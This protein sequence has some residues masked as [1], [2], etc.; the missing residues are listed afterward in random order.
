MKQNKNSNLNLLYGNPTDIKEDTDHKTITAKQVVIDKKKYTVKDKKLSKYTWGFGLEHESHLFHM[1]PENVKKPVKD[2]TIYDTLNS[3]VDLVEYGNLSVMEKEFLESIPFEPTGRKCHGKWVL[4]KTPISMPEFVTKDPFTS[5]KTGKKT[6]EA[7]YQELLEYEKFFLRIQEKKTDKIKKYGQLYQFPYGMSTYIKLAKNYLDD[8]YKY[9][10]KLLTDYLG[11]FHVTITLPFITKDKYTK[12][13]EAEFRK[14]H[15]NFANQFQWIEPLLLSAFFSCDQKAVGSIS[16]R[17]RGS[18]RV[19]RVGWGNFAGTDVRSFDKGTGRYATIPSYWRDHLKFFEI[20]KLKPCYKP[21]KL[22]GEPD[23]LSLLSSNIRTFGSTDPERPWHRV[24]GAP[25]NI[26]NGI[27]IRIFDHFE[28]IYLISLLRI[29]T[30]IAA[31]SSTHHSDKYVYQNKSWIKSMHNIME[32]GWRGE[33]PK[34]YIKDLEEQLDIKLDHNV[35]N[36]Y[37]LLVNLTNQLWEKNKDNDITYMMSEKYLHAPDVP[38][39]NRGSWDFSFLLK[40][41]N[42]SVL[43]KK[44]CKFVK[45]L[46]KKMNIDEFNRF[47]SRDF[48]GKGWERNMLDVLYFLESREIAKFTYK[49]GEIDKI[50]MQEKNFI[51][52]EY[53]TTYEINIEMMG[54]KHYLIYENLRKILQKQ[55]GE[56]RALNNELKYLNHKFKLVEKKYKHYFNT[57]KI[58]AFNFS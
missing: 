6:I 40:L 11:S 43:Y 52:L 32:H 25:M 1:N 23:A 26:P 48:S 49:N 42:S 22:K 58:K 34:D 51:V 7:F 24:S 45:E 31:N 8:K 2:F 36:A 13:E 15:E 57:Y 35:K 3:T 9:E 46:P 38:N 27:E 18:F 50:I 56:D 39:I 21:K 28:T 4:K 19:M 37:E 29:I 12:E 10:K 30:L 55:L 5:I 16:K 53:L 14:R 33:V 41:S 17:I 20:D 47:Y 44:F 54:T